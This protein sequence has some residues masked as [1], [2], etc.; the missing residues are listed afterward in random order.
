MRQPIEKARRRPMIV[1]ILP[2]VII[3]VAITRVY[4]VIAVWMPVT[5]VPR[6][7]ATVAIETFM[8]ELSSVMRNC[9]A[10]RVSRTKPAAAATA[11]CLVIVPPRLVT[12]E[13][14]LAL[15]SASYTGT[16]GSGVTSRS[17]LPQ[18]GGSLGAGCRTLKGR[19]ALRPPALSSVRC[20]ETL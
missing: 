14:H 12:G 3:V 11:L 10:A 9:A 8:T 17:K 15:A 19:V 1:P 4:M 16:H 20:G 7:L 18:P 2:P 5:V 6:S 13:P